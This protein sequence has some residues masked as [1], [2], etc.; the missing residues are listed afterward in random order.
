MPSY[1]FDSGGDCGEKHGTCSCAVRGSPAFCRFHPPCAEKMLSAQL[2][3]HRAVAAVSGQVP[4]TLHNIRT[5]HALGTEDYMEHRYDRSIGE[6]YAAVEKTN[7]YDAIYSPVFFFLAHLFLLHGF[8][9]HS[10]EFRRVSFVW[11]S[12]W[13][14]KAPLPLVQVLYH[15]CLTNGVQF[16]CVRGFFAVHITTAFLLSTFLCRTEAY[17]V[18]NTVLFSPEAQNENPV[19]QFFREKAR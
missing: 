19:P 9:D 10:L 5:I 12:F 7:F 13:H 11:Y 2:D 15:T 3:N 16:I 6:S 1:P 18:R 8:H 14:R 17:K 4:E